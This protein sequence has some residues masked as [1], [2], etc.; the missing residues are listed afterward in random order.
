ML[1][2]EVER[3]FLWGCLAAGYGAVGKLHKR[4]CGEHVAQSA[5]VKLHIDVGAVAHGAVH[6][7]F[8]GVVGCQFASTYTLAAGKC[9]YDVGCV[10][11]PSG[12][13]RSECHK[14]SHAAVGNEGQL[15]GSLIAAYNATGFGHHER[16]LAS[17]DAFL[18]G[19]VILNLQFFARLYAVESK[20][21]GSVRG[22]CGI[23]RATFAVDKHRKLIVGRVSERLRI[24]IDVY[25]SLG[26]AR[27]FARLLKIGVFRIVGSAVNLVDYIFHIACRRLIDSAPTAAVV[28][29]FHIAAFAR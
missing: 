18:L 21:V 12:D 11:G 14:G 28:A 15:F 27:I 6:H 22:C 8:V 16:L 13:G 20:P 17:V 5:A 3:E 24:V 1:V 10:V 2:G 25:I 9:C 19:A 23:H 29:K 7:Q 26:Y 4:C